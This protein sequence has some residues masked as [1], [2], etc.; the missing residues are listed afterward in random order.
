MVPPHAS[1]ANFFSNKL[2]YFLTP[3]LLY[4]RGIRLDKKQHVSLEP[5]KSNSRKNYRRD[6]TGYRV[7]PRG[8]KRERERDLN[9]YWER[10]G[11]GDTVEINSI[12]YSQFRRRLS[13]S[14]QPANLLSTSKTLALS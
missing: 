13:S 9:L 12:R 5:V 3:F 4:R 10:K 2:T 8:K 7:S 14:T 1:F 11:E 6:A